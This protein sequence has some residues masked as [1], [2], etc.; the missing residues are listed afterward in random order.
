MLIVIG[1]VVQSEENY[2]FVSTG[3]VSRT[4]EEAEAMCVAEGAHLPYM[5]SSAE[6]KFLT[7]KKIIT[8][9]LTSN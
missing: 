2:Y 5:L 3:D 7:S 1:K 6:K 9:I 8:I 4:W